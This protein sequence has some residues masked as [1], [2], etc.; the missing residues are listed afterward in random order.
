MKKK[1]LVLAPHTDDGEFGCGGTIAKHI[2]NQDEVWYIAF[3]TC[4]ESLPEGYTVETITSELYEA[5]NK[6]GIN[7]DNVIVLDY[8]VRRFAEHRQDILEDLIKYRKQIVPDIVYSP[9]IHDTHQD[10]NVIAEETRRA[11]KNVCIYAYEA[12]WN[13][14]TFNNQRFNI[15]DASHVEKKLQA[16]QCYKSQNGRAYSSDEFIKGQAKYHGVQVSKDYAEVFEVVR[17]VEEV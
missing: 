8:P 16:V 12:P 17:E 15:L 5:T 6:L 4:K 13:N 9:S 14:F 11:F 2:E 3:S 1:V 7:K 10:H